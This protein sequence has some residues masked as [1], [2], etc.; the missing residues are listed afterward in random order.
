MSGI[1]LPYHQPVIN[2]CKSET[3]TSDVGNEKNTA[4]RRGIGEKVQQ[5]Q[6]KKGGDKLELAGRGIKKLSQQERANKT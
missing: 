2:Y 3:G 4:D 6:M 5:A 1:I